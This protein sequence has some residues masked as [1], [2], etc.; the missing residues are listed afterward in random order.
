MNKPHLFE[1]RYVIDSV[2]FISLVDDIFDGSDDSNKKIVK[3]T[4]NGFKSRIENCFMDETSVREA[5]DG[6][7]EINA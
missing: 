6:F 1:E 3:E 5:E 7:R 4:L 2:D